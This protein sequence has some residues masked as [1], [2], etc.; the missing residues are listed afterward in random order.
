MVT[1]VINILSF[2]ESNYV[3]QAADYKTNQNKS[4]TAKTAWTV[5]SYNRTKSLLGFRRV[6]LSTLRGVLSEHCLVRWHACI[7]TETT[8]EA[9]K[10]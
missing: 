8:A 1:E 4:M 7:Y 6:A 5:Y 9:A 3:E 10:A 2:W